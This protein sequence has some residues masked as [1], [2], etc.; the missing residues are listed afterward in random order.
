MADDSLD[1]QT[2]VTLKTLNTIKDLITLMEAV[3]DNPSETQKKILKRKLKIVS[4]RLPKLGGDIR[5]IVGRKETALLNLGN[6]KDE[7][8]IF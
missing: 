5:T 7:S 4:D 8:I 1:R 6:L 2:I 3:L